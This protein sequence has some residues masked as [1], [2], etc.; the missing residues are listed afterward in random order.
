MVVKEARDWERQHGKS[1]S[2]SKGVGK[3]GS[4][5]NRLHT[6]L[7]FRDFLRFSALAWG[8]SL[9]K[10]GG[11]F[12]VTGIPWRK[13]LELF[14]KWRLGQTGISVVADARGALVVVAL[15]VVAVGQTTA[16]FWVFLGE[17][18]ACELDAWMSVVCASPF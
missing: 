18:D 9:F 1:C 11:P 17:L 13:D 4:T 2:T 12:G 7:L 10:I 6:E 5:G 3:I 15:V 8:T 14:E 16:V